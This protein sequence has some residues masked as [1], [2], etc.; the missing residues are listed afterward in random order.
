MLCDSKIEEYIS[1]LTDQIHVKVLS[2]TNNVL[3][4]YFQSMKKLNI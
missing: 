1:V 3:Y 2:D 4:V